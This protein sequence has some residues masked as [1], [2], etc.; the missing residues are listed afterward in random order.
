MPNELATKLLLALC[1]RKMELLAARWD[2]FDLEARVWMHP[3]GKEGDP[4]AVPLAEPVVRWLEEAK[5]LAGRSEY[6]FPVRRVSK[7]RR[8]PHVSPDTL[9]LALKKVSG[10]LDHF[11][12]HDLR[13]SARTH[14]S[15]LGVAPDVAERALNHVIK[16]TRGVY[17]RYS[18]FDER[19][20]AL[21]IWAARLQT[22]EAAANAKGAS[23]NP[24]A[25]KVAGAVI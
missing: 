19:K 13:R 20:K 6:V 21:E 2:Q 24:L 25:S 8:F 11:T 4:L 1:A 15:G 3:G 7:K 23:V 12:V 14:L 5:G 22:I 16:G 9:N 18:Y 10:G 17:D